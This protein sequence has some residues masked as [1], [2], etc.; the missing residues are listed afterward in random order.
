MLLSHYL[1][2]LLNCKENKTK[3]LFVCFSGK[4]KYIC[5]LRPWC[6]DLH[7]CW[8]L[9]ASNAK[10]PE[11]AFQI[12]DRVWSPGKCEILSCCQLSCSILATFCADHNMKIPNHSDLSTYF[13]NG[14]VS[15]CWSCWMYEKD[16]FSLINIE[17]CRQPLGQRKQETNKY[18]EKLHTSVWN[19][20]PF[21]N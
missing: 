3:P 9:L 10:R 8:Q 16:L 4:K 18:A 7:H 13:S 15:G 14:F 20:D 6:W 1:W 12:P 2:L 21:S 5:V 11:H 17:I 19:P